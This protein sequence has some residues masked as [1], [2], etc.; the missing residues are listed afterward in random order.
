M[1]LLLLI[2]QLIKA[3][4]N[5]TYT[6]RDGEI[7]ETKIT[8]LWSLTNALFIPGGM[9]GAFLGGWLADRLGR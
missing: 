6:E 8:L 2:Q 1:F 3:F 7:S 4:Y 5:E 9:F